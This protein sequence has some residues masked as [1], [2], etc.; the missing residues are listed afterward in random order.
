MIAS[1]MQPFAQTGGLA[2]VL[3]ALPLALGRMG[4]EVTVVVPRYGGISPGAR[5][6]RFVLPLVDRPIEVSV[7]EYDAAPGV[8]AVFIEC[9]T[10]Y[11]REGLYGIGNDDYP[12]NPRRFGCLALAALEY[13][14]RRERVPDV[15]HA[16]DWQA[17]LAP[18]YLRTH[19]GRWPALAGCATA[20]TI[21]NLAYQGLCGADW[22]PR[23]GLAPTLLGIDGIEYWGG[24]SF[25]K[26]G[27]NF[28][29]VV[30]TVSPTYAREVQTAGHGFGFEGILSARAGV[31]VGVLNGIDTGEWSPSRDPH[32]P[33]PYDEAT[34]PEG[35]RAA[36]RRL[37]Q[38]YALPET[39]ETMRRPLVA[40]ISRMVDQ[41][42]LDLLVAL[43]DGLARLGATFVVLG[44]GEARY[45][46]FWTSLAARHRDR[47]SVRI[48]FDG[49]LSHLI[50][51]GADVFLMPSRFEP[52]GL[53][54]MYS[55]R[56][57]TVPVVRATGGLVDTVI[58]YRPGRPDG[59]GFTFAEYSPEALRAAMGRALEAFWKPRVWRAL[60]RR[61]MRQDFS[62]D[63]SAL[64]YVKLYGRA[65]AGRTA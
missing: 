28:S 32:I 43:G 26:G 23:L 59:T 47:V 55:L 57:G 53:N 61:G 12:D 3:A 9:P 29:D 38:R 34:A 2:D 51:A 1:E 8:R 15:V 5:I 45:Q 7:W 62:W 16:H 46:D 39:P 27:I 56:Y 63:R 52:C 18:V 11:D 37:L 60:Q 10:L 14:S 30:T 58:D 65:T 40:M 22:L 24:V 20:F 4:H 42:G 41:K 35:K 48:G 50:E 36:K 44:S 17:G 25:L 33:M 6:D 13:A 49:A 64:E 19:A 21:H 31:L 54:Q